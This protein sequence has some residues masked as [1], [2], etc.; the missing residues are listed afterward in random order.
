MI[1]LDTQ[2]KID[3]LLEGLENNEIQLVSSRLTKEDE[4]E[5]SREIAEYR[6]AHPKPPARDMVLA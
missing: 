5:I 2:E 6:A 3:W 4:A 1:W